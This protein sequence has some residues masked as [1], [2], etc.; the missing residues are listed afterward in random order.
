MAI[1]DNGNRIQYT[2]TAAQT[3][4]P[5]TFRI[6]VNTDLK[7][8]KTP[9]GSTPDPVADLLTLTTDYT[10]SIAVDPDTGGNVTL[11]VGADAGDII[12]IERQVPANRP[13][14]KD[15]STGGDFSA[16]SF[17]DAFSKTRAIEQQIEGLIT[18]RGLTYKVTEDLNSPSGINPNTIPKLEAN[19]VWKMSADGTAISAATIPEGTTCSTLRTDLANNGVGTDGAR[20]VGYSNSTSATDNTVK[21]A[22]DNIYLRDSKVKVSS[23]DT[24]ANYLDDKVKVGTY[25]T[26]TV[27][28]SGAN[29]DILLE[30]PGARHGTFVSAQ[31]ATYTN[32]AAA[33][34]P[35]DDTIPQITEGTEV[36]STS[37][38]S[39]SATSKL[40][41]QIN[42]QCDYTSD[43]GILCAVFRTG[44]N[45]ALFTQ[46]LADGVVGGQGVYAAFSFVVDSPST[47]SETYSIRLGAETAA[48]TFY[49]NGNTSSRHFGGS[50]W[51]QMT[52]TEILA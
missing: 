1:A 46:Y 45:D 42:M 36:M 10:V 12:T 28:N 6:F 13:A 43:H 51:W 14:S 35:V 7:V 20:L 48:G 50:R 41:F 31:Y 52:I 9:N 27:Q 15:Y 33:Q 40:N 16:A 3:I 21:K 2:A 26:K 18:K 17:N 49:I 47:S 34:I 22:L 30:A 19:Q 32:F 29:E 4:F 44:Q 23:D 25:L 11:V 39:T 8:Y 38:T 24:T 5:Y 37:F